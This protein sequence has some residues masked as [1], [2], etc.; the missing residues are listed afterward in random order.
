MLEMAVLPVA[1]DQV[2]LVWEQVLVNV[3]DR[4]ASRQAFDTWFRP[5]VA[6]EFGPQAVDLEVPNA[7]F[8]DWIHEHHLPVLR[9]SFAE[10][11]GF[12]PDIRFSAREPVAL[13]PGPF[14]ATART[15]APQP[16][17]AAGTLS[18]ASPAP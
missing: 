14:T 17:V 1:P 15:V 18:A 11:L 4:L 5:I 13:S 12:S 2:A 9:E 10:V 6:R 16:P 3:R 8:V 7:F